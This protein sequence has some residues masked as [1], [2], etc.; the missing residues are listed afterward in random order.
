MNLLNRVEVAAVFIQGCYLKA[1]DCI[2][3][4]LLVFMS[5][6]SF[7]GNR[8]LFEFGQ[9]GRLWGVFTYIWYQKALWGDKRV[10]WSWSSCCVSY[11][12][13]Q[14][15]LSQLCL[16]CPV[17]STFR[18]LSPLLHQRFLPPFLLYV[19]STFPFPLLCLCTSILYLLKVPQKLLLVPPKTETLIWRTCNETSRACLEETILD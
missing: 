10:L 18:H 11:F 5:L 17:T 9:Y 14:E 13:P 2:I 3:D 8:F 16:G 7:L 19:F 12:A 1:Q 15:S 6:V 4:C